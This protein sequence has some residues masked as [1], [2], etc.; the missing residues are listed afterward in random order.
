MYPS[1]FGSGVGALMVFKVEN[2]MKLINQSQALSKLEEDCGSTPT[3]IGT[4]RVQSKPLMQVEFSLLED[5]SDHPQA[6][7]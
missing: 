1:N 4:C 7:R 3:I 5:D 2:A 6:A